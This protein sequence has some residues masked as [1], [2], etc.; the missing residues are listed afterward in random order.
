M[1]LSPLNNFTSQAVARRGRALGN[2]SIGVLA[3]GTGGCGDRC[4]LFRTS[5]AVLGRPGLTRATRAFGSVLRQ[6]HRT[7]RR[8]GRHC[9]KTG[10]ADLLYR[11]RRTSR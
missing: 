7:R 6:W 2:A 8:A 3:G 11:G 10:F 5:V 9:A 4:K 1:V